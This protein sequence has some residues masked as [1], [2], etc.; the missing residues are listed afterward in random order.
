MSKDETLL[1][2]TQADRDAAAALIAWHNKAASDW[3]TDGGN[4]LT[5][6]AANMPDAIRKGVWDSHDVVQA[7]ARHR[8]SHSLPGDVGM[9]PRLDDGLIEAAMLAHY[10]KWSSKLG[11]NGV[12][13]TAND[14]NWTFRD[15]FKRMWAGVRKELKRRAAL[16]PSPCPG[17]GM[18]EA[19]VLPVHPIDM[20]R[21]MLAREIAR[22]STTESF[23]I[24]SGLLADL[25]DELASF[26]QLHS[27]PA[28]PVSLAEKILW[29]VE[30]VCGPLSTE[31]AE[32][33]GDDDRSVLLHNIRA[34]HQGAGE[35]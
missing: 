31:V 14:T 1:P 20:L 28:E 21:E 33:P 5:F 10:G 9:L 23:M 3:K 4:D 6:F 30:Q 16:T 18:R 25:L 19:S 34:A 13:L 26:R 15:G 35:P 17:D 8:I 12:D 7:F 32:N 11:I 2:V 29:H 22:T 24:R 27:L